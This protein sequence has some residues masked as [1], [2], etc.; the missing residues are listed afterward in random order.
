MTLRLFQ[1]AVSV[2]PA[3]CTA[4]TGGASTSGNAAITSM[5]VATDPTNSA[6][7]VATTSSSVARTTRVSSRCIAATTTRIVPT[8]RTRWGVIIQIACTS[9]RTESRLWLL[10]S[11]II[12]MRVYCRVGDAMVMTIVGIIRTRRDVLLV[13]YDTLS[14]THSLTH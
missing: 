5:T 6:A 7:G 3:T 2:R 14:P 4:P 10:L 13:S 11:V 12:R 1:R 9:T 8:P